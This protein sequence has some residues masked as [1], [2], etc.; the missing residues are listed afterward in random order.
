MSN[1]SLTTK[2]NEKNKKKNNYKLLW[3]LVKKDGHIQF[4]KIKQSKKDDKKNSTILATITRKLLDDD[5]LCNNLISLLKAEDTIVY[6]RNRLIS[7]E[8]VENADDVGDILDNFGCQWEL[9]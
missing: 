4:K 9:E 3:Q 2:K 7:I 8:N 1:I 5:K 6:K